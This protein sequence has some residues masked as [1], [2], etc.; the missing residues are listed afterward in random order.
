[1]R[2]PAIELEPAEGRWLREV[3]MG[4]GEA[5]EVRLL[6]RVDGRRVLQAVRSDSG[7]LRRALPELTSDPPGGLWSLACAAGA[8][9]VVSL[10]ARLAPTPADFTGG[11][12][13]RLADRRV[14]ADPPWCPAFEALRDDLE[15]LRGRLRDGA[16]GMASPPASG[17]GEASSEPRPGGE[18]WRV[19]CLRLRAGVVERVCGARALGL[20]PNASS[21][22]LCER[23]RRRVGTPH[24]LLVA[25]P[26]KLRAVAASDRP[27]SALERATI[28]GEIEVVA[29]SGPLAVALHALR[30][31][32]PLRARRRE[33][34]RER[35]RTCDAT[36]PG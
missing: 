21:A 25:P 5:S 10:P 34:R 8:Q 6:A 29:R 23:V 13:E 20:D 36:S 17:F 35:D 32:E 22:E 33:R 24:L 3:L 16:Y 14:L 11:L 18:G 4:A 30:L 19:A 15:R 26:A 1:V 9:R 12:L 28:R 2:R 7:P 27:L 31:L